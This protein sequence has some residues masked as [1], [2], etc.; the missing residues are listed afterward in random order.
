MRIADSKIL[1]TD[2]ELALHFLDCVL[3][4]LKGIS[5]HLTSVETSLE[6][7]ILAGAVSFTKRKK[8]ECKIA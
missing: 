3:A 2:F 7:V 5:P 4:L 1:N 6:N 8:S